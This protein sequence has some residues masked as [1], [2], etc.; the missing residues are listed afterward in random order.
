L[1]GRGDDLAA[2]EQS[3]ET[4]QRGVGAIVVV[5]G[6][7]GIG[8]SRLVEEFV[9]RADNALAVTGNCVDAA[10]DAL[11]YAPWTELLWWLVRKIGTD[12]LGPERA[13]LARLLPELASDTSQ[14]ESSRDLLFEAVVEVLHRC[15]STRPVIAVVEDVH[16]I[17]PASRDVLLCVARNLRRLPMLLVVT[18]RPARANAELRELLGHLDRFGATDITL[19]ALGDDEAAD[20]ASLLIGE[21]ATAPEVLSIVGRA[22]GNP[23]F[24]EEFSAA[25]SDVL[26]ST[27]RHLM[28]SRFSALSPDAKR[29]VEHA[30]VIGNRVPRSW[31]AAS[32]ELEPDVTRAC[33]RETVDAGVLGITR[34]KNAYVFSHSL[35]RETILEELVPGDLVALHGDV[36]RGLGTLSVIDDDTDVVGELAR[37]WDAAGA[38]DEALRWTAAAAEQAQRRYAFETA[39]ALYERA[40][41]WWT[42]ATDA[43]ASSAFT[44]A[45]LLFG[46]ADACGA[47][48]RLDDAATLALRA[49]PEAPNPAEAFS[50]ARPHLWAVGR[51]EELA[52]IEAEAMLRLDELEPAVRAAF[53]LDIG[54]VAWFDSRPGDAL[55]LRDAIFS[56][57]EDAND[58]ALEVRALQLIALSYEVLGEPDAAEEHYLRALAVAQHAELYE[59]V[60]LV[61]YNYASFFQTYARYDECRTQ[62]DLVVELVETHGI[63]RLLVAERTLRAET[64]CN[65][66]DL[67]AAARLLEATRALAI[68]G[69]DRHAFAYTDALLSLLSGN[70][71]TARAELDPHEFEEGSTDDLARVLSHAHLRAECLTWSG[72]PAGAVK[73]VDE[74]LDQLGERL[75]VF[76]CGFVCLAGVHALAVL[77]NS[78]SRRADV[79]LAAQ[80]RAEELAV[81]W[82]DAY[83]KWP[84]RYPLFD[85]LTAGIEAELASIRRTDMAESAR[86]AACEFEQLGMPYYVTYFEL[87]EAQALIAGRDRRSPTP[88]LVSARNR[89]VKYGFAGLRHAV[90]QIARSEQ[91]RLGKVETTSELLSPREVE[92]LRLLSDGLSNPEI[93]ETLI[94]GRRTVRTHVSNILT[95]LGTSSRAEAVSVAHKREIL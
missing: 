21:D 15:A 83:A 51:S 76:W 16:W 9:A 89:A 85:A 22:E 36:A 92:V 7:A 54:Y 18:H 57:S 1:V 10:T 94:I 5:E 27:I 87:L 24:L 75:E 52:S 71:S 90:E 40:L 6:E 20:V 86:R 23:L 68:E 25:D 48:G 11:A 12:A 17:D 80:E 29:L 74:A 43:H 49:I 2:L 32:V 62:L 93:A 60:A 78:Q 81:I 63:R 72:D 65:T 67:E 45:E 46:A 37:H 53:L 35:L 69:V 4:T 39:L 31:L 91:I 64:L 58:P 61:A 44:Y 38:A 70:A 95:K 19:A 13:Q 77:A 73:I 66:G 59:L 30:A 84:A 47:A 33:E 3:L 50:R 79:D 56:A 8:K 14:G 28:L 26:P 34:E 82:Q 41:R 42:S 88:V 55:S